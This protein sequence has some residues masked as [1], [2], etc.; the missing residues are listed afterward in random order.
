MATRIFDEIKFFHEILKGTMAGI[1]LWN[2]I[3]IGYVG[4]EKKMFKIK[5]NAQTDGHTMDTGLLHNHGAGLW[6]VN[7]KMKLASGG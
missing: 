6:P 1:F 3:K 7:L 5:I 2:F 4:S